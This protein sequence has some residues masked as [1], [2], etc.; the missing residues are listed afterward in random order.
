M[1]QQ[2]QEMQQQI[3]ALKQ[4]QQQQP[5]QVALPPAAPAAAAGAGRSLRRPKK[6]PAEP[7]FEKFIKGFFG[8]LDVSVDMA[9]KGISHCRRVPLEPS[10]HVPEPRTQSLCRMRIPRWVRSAASVGRRIYQPTNRCSAIV[11]RTAFPDTTVDFI[12]Q[13][14]VQPQITHAPGV[15]DSYTSQS[16]VTKGGIGYGDTFVGLSNTD[17]GKLKFGTTYTPTRDPPIA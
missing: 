13:L 5:P 7:Q 10:P 3:Q 15:G 6:P 4:Q 9:T 1:Q 14:E 11:A 8:T 16:D 17:W 2:M 12:Y